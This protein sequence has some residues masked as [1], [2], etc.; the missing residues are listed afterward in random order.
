MNLSHCYPC[1][2]KFSSWDLRIGS[3]TS[4][5]TSL[6][7]GNPTNHSGTFKGEIVMPLCSDFRHQ[8]N[9]LHQLPSGIILF[10]FGQYLTVLWKIVVSE[11][12]TALYIC[13]LDPE[14]CKGTSVHSLTSLVSH[15]VY[16]YSPQ[17]LYISNHT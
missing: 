5:G 10:D 7:N 6:Q 1:P 8:V 4:S 11:A 12:A 15:Y 9:F 14:F 13:W 3:I 16:M 2:T 17:S